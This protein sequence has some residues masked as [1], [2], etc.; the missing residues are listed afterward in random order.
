M[1][2]KDLKLFDHVKQW[3]LL[4]SEDFMHIHNYL[5][6]LIIIRFL[7]VDQFGLD[8]ILN[9]ME[10]MGFEDSNSAWTAAGSR[11]LL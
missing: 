4:D 1:I 11:F 9:E 6:Y 8:V 5:T 2:K 7:F 3:R 10:M